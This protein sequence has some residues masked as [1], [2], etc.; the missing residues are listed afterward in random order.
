M[1]A[2]TWGWL[3]MNNAEVEIPA[4]LAPKRMVVVITAGRTLGGHPG[5]AHD[6][7]G[8]HRNA[9]TDR[10]G[11]AG[12]LADPQVTIGA[13]GEACGIGTAGLGCDGE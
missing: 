7:S 9:K 6:D 11:R 1:P 10:L 13:I 5:M 8:I 12:F 3:K 2:P 4:G